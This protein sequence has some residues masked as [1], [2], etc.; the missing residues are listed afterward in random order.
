MQSRRCRIKQSNVLLAIAVDAA[1]TLGCNTMACKATSRIALILLAQIVFA[2]CTD[3]VQP[4]VCGPLDDTLRLNQIQ[5]LGTHNSYHVAKEPPFHPSVAY[6][7]LPLPEQLA[8][9][10][11]RHFE[12]DLHKR[13]GQAFEVFHIPGI[14]EKTRCPNLQACLQD[15]R[16]WSDENP[17]HQP[18]FV[19]FEPKDK[20]DEFKLAGQ[21]D[22]LDAE[23]LQAFPRNRILTPDDVRGSHPDLRTAITLPD[24]KGW[25][26][27][28]AVRG[29]VVF[30]MMDQEVDGV[31]YSQDY[32]A[33]HPKFAGRLMFLF[34]EPHD[35][36]IAFVKDDNPTDSL[37]AAKALA[38]KGYML[39]GTTDY[40]PPKRL[41]SG[42]RRDAVLAAM[43]LVTTDW[44]T[45][46]ANGWVVTLP[47]GKPSRCHPLTGP[48]GC[49][50]AAVEALP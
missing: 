15:L 44:P 18:L 30:V 27:L 34:G 37:D 7:H 39:R 13:P 19:L 5:V 16:Q 9:Q 31:V 41:E 10:G 42:P 43:H 20:L 3:P 46:A 6:S 47:G 33:G 22:A 25:P 23:L 26:T 49:T 29:K 12:L 21:W 2:A 32:K 50:A 11:I 4:T 35:P 14:D 17:C 24:G 40:D 38:L 28:G 8:Q 48:V 45:P 1:A 36:D